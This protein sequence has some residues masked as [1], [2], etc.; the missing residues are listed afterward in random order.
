MRKVIFWDKTYV[1]IDNDKEE[2]VVAA[3][4]G[5]KGFWLN[6]AAGRDWIASGSIARITNAGNE[7]FKPDE[8]RM[9]EEP[10]REPFDPKNPGPGYKKFQDA[11]DKLARKKSV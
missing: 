4:K 1:L 9:I 11:R 10:K 2:S 8:T 7:G 3:M 5:E 6:H